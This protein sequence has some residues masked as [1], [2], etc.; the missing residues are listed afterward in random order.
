[1]RR[2]HQSSRNLVVAVAVLLSAWTLTGPARAEVFK[3]ESFRLP[4]GL[5]VVVISNH[6]APIV[7]QMLWYKVG[8]AD[9]PR[10]K[11]GIAH[12]LEHLMFKGTRSIP[13]GQFSKIVARNGGQDNAFTS[14]DYTAYLQRVAKDK[15]E[16]VMRLEAD[17]MTNLTL[18]DDVVLPER[19]VV[20]E[21]HG[22]RT[23]NNPG[24]QL[25]EHSRA[26]LY[27]HH[28]YRI[29]VIGWHNEIGRLATADAIAFYREH[30]A[31]NNAILVVAGDVT[32]DRVKSL[33]QK[34]YGPIPR[35][36][37]PARVRVTEP[38]HRAARRVELKSRQ[39]R[40]PRWSRVFLAPS[41]VA[42][43]TEHA[44]ALQV[45]AE[46]FG[47]GT[48]SRLYKSLVVGGT[49]AASASAWYSPNRLDNG[50]FG[51]AISPRPGAEMAKLQNA[52]V[53]E[54]DRLLSDGVT[55]D[56]VKRAKRSLLAGAVYVRDSL[57]AG[58]NVFG[59]ALTT[60]RTIDDVEAWPERIGA[61]TVDQVNAA[62][63][64]VLRDARSVTNV[65]LPEGA[66]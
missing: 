65:L 30:Y 6:R 53:G 61:V 9:E 47:G 50:E 58:P 33:A 38:E 41:Y 49:L 4:N 14:H 11:S 32:V 5:Q 17:R 20:L 44:Y 43:R 2:Y 51:V 26:A 27:L 13:P 63:R 3:P 66:G 22:S 39:V 8:S 1:M 42:G 34:Y 29:P 55:A 48:T 19:D 40:Q 37:V 60:G 36:D 18:T 31:P 35:R 23:G 10:G 59:Q 45:L 52:M 57:R 56:E 12:F 25:Y 24:A 64:A 21:E 46:L 54:I 16:L 62:M 7:I 15:L 28:P